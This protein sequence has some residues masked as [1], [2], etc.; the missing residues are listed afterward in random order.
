LPNVIGSCSWNGDVSIFEWPHLRRWTGWFFWEL[1]ANKQKRQ[2]LQLC[3]LGL[4]RKAKA[5]DIT[6]LSRSC[7]PAFFCFF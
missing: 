1:R 3:T 6:V 2:I 4:N 5:M 7:Y